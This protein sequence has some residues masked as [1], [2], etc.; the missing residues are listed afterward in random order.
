[1]DYCKRIIKLIKESNIPKNVIAKDLGVSP[2]NI[3]DW[4]KG[5]SKPS[6]VA[7]LKI[8]DYFDVTLD[9]IFGRSE[10]SLQNLNINEKNLINNYRAAS[11]LDQQALLQI[12]GTLAAATGMTNAADETDAGLVRQIRLDLEDQEQEE[13]QVF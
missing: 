11:K 7:I 2:G 6:V 4:E 5:R 8:A 1:M 3:T 12:S 13:E 9:F 10:K